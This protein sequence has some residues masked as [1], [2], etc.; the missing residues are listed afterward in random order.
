MKQRIITAEDV[1]N[2]TGQSEE[3]IKEKWEAIETDQNNIA[4]E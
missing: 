2:A 4:N 3:K 1:A